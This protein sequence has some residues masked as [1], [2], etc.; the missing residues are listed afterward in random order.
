MNND[1]EMYKEKKSSRFLVVL[2]IFAVFAIAIVIG[3]F[4]YGKTIYE[5]LSV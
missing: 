1:Q 5:G 3:L 4:I 2:W